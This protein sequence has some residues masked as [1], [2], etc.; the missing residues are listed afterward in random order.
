MFI[1]IQL[2]AGGHVPPKIVFEEELEL[3]GRS[4]LYLDHRFYVKTIH[5]NIDTGK[6][7]EKIHTIL[8]IFY[9]WERHNTHKFIDINPTPKDENMEI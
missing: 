3:E 9:L 8:P 2:S 5:V 6:R 4:S 7:E 1:K